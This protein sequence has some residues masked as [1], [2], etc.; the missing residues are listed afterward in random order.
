MAS[1]I[2]I[3]NKTMSENKRIRLNKFIANSGLCSRRDADSLIKSG[4][5]TV[6]GEKIIQLGTKVEVTDIIKINGKRLK[7]ERLKYVLLNKAKTNNLTKTIIKK[8]YKESI[9]PVDKLTEIESGLLLLT[10]D[11]DLKNK[12]EDKKKSVKSVYHI[13]L[14]KEFKEKDIKRMN[15]FNSISAISYVKGKTKKE[16]GIENTYGG[17][18]SVRKY[19]IELGYSID[20]LDRVLFAGLTKK[21]L[22]RKHY[23]NLT[24]N[25]VGLLKRI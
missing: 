11:K 5:V 16:V 14:D 17:V 4:T 9:I 22:P 13:S 24:A 10:N 15:Q 2:K 8:A 1:K 23:R 3:R 20:A 19:F 12:L 6:N 25:E 18:Q 7:S 21:D